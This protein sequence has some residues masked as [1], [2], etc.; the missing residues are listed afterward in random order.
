MAKGRVK[1]ETAMQKCQENA[2][3]KLTKCH[4]DGLN[5]KKQNAEYTD[6][7]LQQYFKEMENYHK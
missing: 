2:V 6:D 7:K 5:D 4:A 1:F 3:I